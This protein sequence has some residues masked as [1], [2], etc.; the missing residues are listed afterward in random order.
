VIDLERTFPVYAAPGGDTAADT[1]RPGFTVRR[2]W[3]LRDFGAEI[4]PRLLD[5]YRRE[6]TPRVLHYA[7]EAWGIE[8]RN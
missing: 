8:W 6:S 3:S 1:R 7:L 5:L 2:A 4:A